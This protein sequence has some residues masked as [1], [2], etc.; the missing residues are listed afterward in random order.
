MTRFSFPLALLL[1]ASLF[2]VAAFLW[3]PALAQDKDKVVRPVVKWEYKV[4]RA[5]RS[6]ISET[7]MEETLNKL[8]DQG[9]E[10]VATLAEVVEKGAATN[11]I[12]ICKRPKQ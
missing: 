6:V 12:L 9:W 5:G 10:C 8:G 3:R 11:A 4:V 7:R 2:V 1:A